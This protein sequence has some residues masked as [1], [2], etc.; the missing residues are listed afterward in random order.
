MVISLMLSLL[1][2]VLILATFNM[3]GSQNCNLISSAFVAC[4]KMVQSVAQPA[5]WY[6]AVEHS[7]K[8][9]VMRSKL[10]WTLLSLDS[11]MTSSKV[12]SSK[13]VHFLGK[14]L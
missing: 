1:S 8:L 6:K 14:A 3:W 11:T 9:P 5:I 13:Y 12:T 4:L 10:V 2:W 7:Y